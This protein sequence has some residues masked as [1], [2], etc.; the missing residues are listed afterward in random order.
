MTDKPKKKSS[1]TGGAWKGAPPYERVTFEDNSG[2]PRVV[3]VPP[4]EK[5]KMTG[6]PL[7]LD[8]SP[9]YGHMPIEFQRALTKALHDHGLIEPVDFFKPGAADRY[10]RAMRTVIKHD[11][12]SL[13]KLAKQELKDG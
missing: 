12:L 4:D 1:D 5:D 2:I 13:Q 11:F 10:Q 9:L 6:I 7:S 8:L 3:L